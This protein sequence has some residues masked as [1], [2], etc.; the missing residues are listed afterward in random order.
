[1]ARPVTECQYALIIE[2]VPIPKNR[3]KAWRAGIR[4]LLQLLKAERDALEAEGIHDGLD[5]DHPDNN[6]VR[7][8][9]DGHAPGAS[10]VHQE[11]A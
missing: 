9:V 3:V 5:I 8:V 11:D 10:S 4:L 7:F 6:R 2:Y 1:M